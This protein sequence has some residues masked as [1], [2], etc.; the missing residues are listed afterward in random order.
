MRRARTL[1]R[2]GFT[3][4]ELI[5][6][7]LLMGIVAVVATAKWP[8]DMKD[9]A[10]TMELKRALRYAQHQAMTRAFTSGNAWGLTIAAN[11]Y[12]IQRQDGETVADFSGRFL[13]EDSA[14]TLQDPTAGDGLWFNGLGE[15]I[16]SSGAAV[17]PLTFTVAGSIDLTV[18]PQ[19]G[20][21]I[22]GS[23]P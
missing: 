10:A 15:P 19:T 9:E 3:L 8:G 14:I 13:L 17:G 7:I 12:T 2:R 6:I 23:C 5:T 11:Q 1:G 4:I 18:C 22:E 21:V 16:S 20:Y